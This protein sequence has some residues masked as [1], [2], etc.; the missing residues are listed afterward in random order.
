[1]SPTVKET[2]K[3]LVGFGTNFD[4]QAYN[5]QASSAASTVL[6]LLLSGKKSAQYR[7]WSLLLVRPITFPSRLYFYVPESFYRLLNPGNDLV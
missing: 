6:V 2:V 1:M 7:K 3:G 4:H 5:S